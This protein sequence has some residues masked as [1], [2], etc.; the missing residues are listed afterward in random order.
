MKK[1]EVSVFLAVSALGLSGCTLGYTEMS[2]GSVS[3]KPKSE[4][5]ALRSICDVTRLRARGQLLKRIGIENFREIALKISDEITQDEIADLQRLDI[6]KNGQAD[7]TPEES[8]QRT[9]L[10]NEI[11][12]GAIRRA[13]LTPFSTEPIQGTDFTYH[14]GVDAVTIGTD[15][16]AS[17]VLGRLS[18]EA[19][20][21][22]RFSQLSLS[23]SPNQ[24]RYYVELYQVT[25]Y[26]EQSD[27]NK[28][29][30]YSIMSLY[31]AVDAVTPRHCAETK[32]ALDLRAFNTIPGK[33]GQ[34]Q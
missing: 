30:V 7:L 4:S 8:R 18:G 11:Y 13:G 29:P 6:S 22:G 24:S 23:A 10:I 15:S 21:Q 5:S 26:E 14:V 34:A 19:D 1:F 9:G 2:S 33:G 16:Y 27:G 20:Q 3:V 32:T 12:T 17:I 25:G 31:D 28:R